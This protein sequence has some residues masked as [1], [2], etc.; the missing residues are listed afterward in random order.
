VLPLD[1][2]DRLELQGGCFNPDI[3][4]EATEHFEDQW[5]LDTDV[6]GDRAIHRLVLTAALDRV[7]TLVAES[8]V[9]IEDLGLVDGA[10]GPRRS[11]RHV[12][13]GAPRRRLTEFGT[14]EVMRS[15]T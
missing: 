11:V 10:P 3:L 14:S 7:D 1:E 8:G 2:A 12:A 15:P 6:D 5:Q 9:A 13:P 4:P